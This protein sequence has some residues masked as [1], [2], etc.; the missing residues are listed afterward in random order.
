MTLSS[1]TIWRRMKRHPTAD[2]CPAKA[3]KDGRFDHAA[4]QEYCRA[5]YD[6]TPS[7]ELCGKCYLKK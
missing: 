1:N 7:P 4:C 3:V 6:Y 5:I 2:V